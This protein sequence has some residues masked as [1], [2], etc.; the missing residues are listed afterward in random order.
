MIIWFDGKHDG[1]QSNSILPSRPRK[2]IFDRIRL[3][4]R[5][6]TW[7]TRQRNTLVVRSVTEIQFV[8]KQ[9]HISGD[10]VI[11]YIIGLRDQRRNRKS[12][13]SLVYNGYV[14][15]CTDRRSITNHLRYDNRSV[16]V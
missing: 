3:V 16:T 6:I 4:R 9:V 8:H 7:Y 1:K 13:H 11:K 5:T 15:R 14:L 12:A 10:R 2:S